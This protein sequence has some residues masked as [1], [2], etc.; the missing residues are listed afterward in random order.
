MKTRILTLSFA[1]MTAGVLFTGCEG[2]EGPQGPAGA[3]GDTGAT[4]AQGA[5]GPQGAAGATGTAN[6]IYTEWKT[7]PVVPSSRYSDEK[8]YRIAEPKIT[9][10]I[11]DS[12]LVQAYVRSGASSW[13]YY[14]PQILT[15]SYTGF[16]GNINFYFNM[17]Q[18]SL[19]YSELWVGPAAVNTSWNQ[20]DKP[21]YFSQIRYLIIPGGTKARVG[22]LDYSDYE[23]VKKHYNLPD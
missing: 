5:T 13:A 15:P 4:G 9:K 18:G 12:G 2:P 16:N 6:V 10:E 19:Y 23:A 20:Q 17:V 21:T 14:L 11:F 8:V 22:S 1:L 3:K 7:I